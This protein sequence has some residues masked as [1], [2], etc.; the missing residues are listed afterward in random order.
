[1]LS[2]AINT[3]GSGSE[4][5]DGIA[6][7]SVSSHFYPLKVRAIK[8]ET[9]DAVTVAFDIPQELQEK[10]QFI[11]GQYLTFRATVG[12][13]ELRRSYSICSAV[14]DGSLRVAIKRTP[15]GIFS[16]WVLENLKPGDVIEVMPPEGR[17]HVQLSPLN[18]K[19][20]V[21]FAAGSGITPIFSIVKTTLLTEP[22]SSFTLFFGNRA[23]NTVILRE[24]LADLK[25]RFMERF[26]LVH[27]TSREHQDVDL[28][29][30]RITADKT[31]RLLKQFC[32][33]ENLDTVFLC[34]PQE[35]VEEVAARLKTLGF[36]ESRIKIELFTVKDAGERK[37]RNGAAPTEE[38]CEVT[39]IVDGARQVFSMEK[40][41][42]S[43]LDAALNRGIDLRHSCKSGVCATC[44]ARLLEG[45]VD[46][47]ANYALEDSE[48][49][50]GFILTCQS[51]PLT[52][53]VTVD[54][55]Q[56]N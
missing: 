37:I 43:I 25:D 12:G 52:D 30:G 21:A 32:R 5:I 9:R 20:Y 44:R 36:P 26:S 33:F 27:I 39:L 48:V 47:N 23:S 2:S 10:F 51:H 49:A 1:M 55:D 24:E 35:M 38:K 29:N 19:E 53:R 17:F 4:S 34:G 41:N 50:R 42:E 45:R 6:P 22:G 8:Q 40:D 18:K 54:F 11:Q 56:D 7:E 16:N 46:M 31:E 14:Q 3:S 28:L 15:G 13:E